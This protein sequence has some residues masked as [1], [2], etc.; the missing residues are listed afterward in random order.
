MKQGKIKK[1]LRDLRRH[2]VS[3]EAENHTQNQ[4][5]TLNH[6]GPALVYSVSAGT[7]NP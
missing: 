5:Q 7:P 6:H 2:L 1:L 3:G 4:P